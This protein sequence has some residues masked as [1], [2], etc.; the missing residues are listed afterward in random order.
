MGGPRKSK[1]REKATIEGSQKGTISKR[2]SGLERESFSL[3]L[4]GGKGQGR[5]KNRKDK[6]G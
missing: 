5:I 3:V 1:G 2:V 4:L 6:K